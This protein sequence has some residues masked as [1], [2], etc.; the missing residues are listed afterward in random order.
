[1]KEGKLPIPIFVPAW[2]DAMMDI[3]IPAT[4]LYT[5]E[6]LF[7]EKMDAKHQIWW[8]SVPRR[9]DGEPDMRYRV[10]KEDVRRRAELRP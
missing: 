3:E 5:W 2:W 7:Y 10:N 4:V 1:M 9:K 8:L 6:A